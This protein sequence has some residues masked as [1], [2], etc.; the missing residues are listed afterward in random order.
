MAIIQNNVYLFTMQ[1]KRN[2]FHFSKSLLVHFQCF[3]VLIELATIEYGTHHIKEL[4]LK[5]RLQLNHVKMEST[6]K[7]KIIFHWNE[8]KNSIGFI[9][10][11]QRGLG[12]IINY[13]RVPR[14][15]GMEKISTYSYFGG[16]QTHSYVMFSKSILEIARSSGLAG[17]IFH[18]SNIIMVICSWQ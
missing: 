9:D 3:M 18:L 5:Q 10:E 13:V 17:I 1:K 14:E 4:V 7:K 15:G 12:P 6:Q 8:N 16:G 2:Y 11:Q